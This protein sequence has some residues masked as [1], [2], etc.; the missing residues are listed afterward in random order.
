M[1]PALALIVETKPTFPS[2]VPKLPAQVRAMLL[3]VVKAA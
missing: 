3:N 1:R 2:S